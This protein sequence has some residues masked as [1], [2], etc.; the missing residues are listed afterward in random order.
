MKKILGFLFSV[1]FVILPFVEGKDFILKLEREF[2]VDYGTSSFDYFNGKFY[3]SNHLLNQIIICNEKGEELNRIGKKGNGP[4]EFGTG[5]PGSVLIFEGKILVNDPGNLR[6]QIFDLNGN[7]LKQLKFMKDIPLFPLLKIYPVGKNKLGL[8]GYSFEAKE[9]EA[10]MYHKFL[11]FNLE[12][13]SSKE[14]YSGFY[15]KFDMESLRSINPFSGFPPPVL[16]NNFVFQ[17]DREDYF[18]EIY[19]IEG[20]KL[21]EIKRKWKKVSITEDLKKYFSEKEEFQMA[22]KLSQGMIDFA[23]PSHF[24]PL[25]GILVLGDKLLVETWKSWYEK[26]FKGKEKNFYVDIFDLEGEY[27]GEGKTNF[28]VDEVEIIKEGKVFVLHR[29]EEKKVVRVFRQ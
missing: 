13:N 28:E 4:S 24:P 22:K 14:I 11:V 5:S 17:A 15:G 1:L 25:K 18:I 9:N 23:F 20:K 27:I 12:D 19:D 6:L 7:F 29:E 21:K 3:L 26:N 2:E 10:K 8:Y 16:K